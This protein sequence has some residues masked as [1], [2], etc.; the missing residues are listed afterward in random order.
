MVLPS[1]ILCGDNTQIS[2][3]RVKMSLYGYTWG[4]NWESDV[5]GQ[6]LVFFRW[7][8]CFESRSWYINQVLNG[9]GGPTLWHKQLGYNHSCDWRGSSHFSGMLSHI[10]LHSRHQPEQHGILQ[11]CT[12]PFLYIFIFRSPKLNL[13]LQGFGLQQSQIYASLSGNSEVLSTF[14]A[15]A[16]GHFCCLASSLLF[17]QSPI[18]VRNPWDRWEGTCDRHATGGTQGPPGI[19][20]KTC[21]GMVPLCSTNTF[22]PGEVWFLWFCI[23]RNGRNGIVT[24]GIVL[25]HRF[26]W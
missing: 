25:H 2:P 15:F 24:H 11:S 10:H 8:L 12:V 7:R 26:L 19:A 14:L 18:F 16:I 9:E 23:P 5:A 17:L 4:K 1:K 21:W 13:M 22:L 6:D 3:G 20:V